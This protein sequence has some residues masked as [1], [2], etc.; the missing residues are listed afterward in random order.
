M[1][2]IMDFKKF[3]FFHA[4][5]DNQLEKLLKVT[6]KKTFKKGTQ[7]YKEGDRANQ[8]YIVCKGWVKLRKIDPGKGIDISF[9]NRSKGELFGAACFMKPQEYTLNAVCMEDSEVMAINADDLFDLFHKDYQ[10]GYLFLKEIAKVYFERY[11]SVKR[12]LYGM[13]QD[14][15]TITALPG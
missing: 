1:K 11:K 6:E 15:A 13:V 9:E 2:A 14:P 5:S 10:I 8:I 4:F 3:D 12:Q 7:I